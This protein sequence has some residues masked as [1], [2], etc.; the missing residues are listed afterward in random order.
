M[1]HQ[2]PSKE[3]QDHGQILYRRKEYA[4]ALEL[5]NEAI[6]SEPNLTVSLL[7]NRAATYEKLDDTT[8][9][10]KDAKSAIRLH[11]KDP[12]GYL[13]AGKL[14]EKAGKPDVALSIYKHG[15]KKQTKNVQLLVKM[16]DKL[17]RS[18][19]PPTAAD[20]FVQLPLELVEMILAH[21]SFR[22]IV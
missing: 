20:P 11:E 13:R 6:T 10:L 7:D 19:A 17:L 18:T 1:P 5:F 16:H 12:T 21:L 2:R 22:Q 9:A 14:L 15:I 3:L 8:S 4:K